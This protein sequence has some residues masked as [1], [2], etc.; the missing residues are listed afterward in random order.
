MSPLGEAV[1]RAQAAGVPDFEITQ[2]LRGLGGTDQ[3]RIQEIEVLIRKEQRRWR[4]QRKARPSWS[5]VSG[6]SR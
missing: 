4:L 3:T 2:V 6:G 1:K 5:R